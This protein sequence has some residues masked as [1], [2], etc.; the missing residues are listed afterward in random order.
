ML[1]KIRREILRM[2]VRRQLKNARKG[3]VMPSG[4]DKVGVRRWG[5][6]ERAESFDNALLHLL[7]FNSD[8]SQWFVLP[9]A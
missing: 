1:V 2:I 4:R 9:F 5:R 3:V 7:E 8:F 6:Q